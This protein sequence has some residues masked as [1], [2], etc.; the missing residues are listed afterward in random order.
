M[1]RSSKERRAHARADANERRLLLQ[2]RVLGRWAAS[3]PREPL[4]R[5]EY[6]AAHEILEACGLSA[7]GVRSVGSDCAGFTHAVLAPKAHRP[8]CACA[9]GCAWCCVLEVSAWPA[10]VIQLAARLE[11]RAPSERSVLLARL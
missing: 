10:E 9:S 4:E 5:A 8:A 6:F 2:R 3:A 7:G 11:S 1:S